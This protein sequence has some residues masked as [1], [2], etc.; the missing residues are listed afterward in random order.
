MNAL[1][2]A[3]VARVMELI[4]TYILLTSLLVVFSARASVTLVANA[5]ATQLLAKERVYAGHETQKLTSTPRRIKVVARRTTTN[6][7]KKAIQEAFDDID[8]VEIAT[9][10][11]VVKL[12]SLQE[13]PML[14]MRQFM[15]TPGDKKM[16]V[17]MDI[18]QLCLINPNDWDKISVMP[19][20]EVNRLIKNW[21]D[22][23]DGNSGV[24][25]E[26]ED[27]EDNE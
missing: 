17:L 24:Y 6:R 21:M 9:S 23:S 13:M 12:I 16:V 10:I 11:G 15:M 4:G 22:L 2:F 3:P 20:K 8:Q 7:Q 1:L 14:Q 5:I 26:E 25:N 19:I 18:L 27:D